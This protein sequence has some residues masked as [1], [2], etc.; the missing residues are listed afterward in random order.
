[1]IHKILV[2]ED[3]VVFCKL[4]TRFLSK[5]E[6]VTNDA[7]KASDAYALMES[8]QYDLAILDYR[9]PG[10][11]GLEILKKI[12]KEYPDMKVILISRFG[13]TETADEAKS[14]GA[15]AYVSKPINPDELLEVIHSLK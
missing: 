8:N 2:V 10:E 7:Q 11:N 12:K 5:K 14:L 1:M 4:L 3:D 15:E 9:L 6:F 13:D